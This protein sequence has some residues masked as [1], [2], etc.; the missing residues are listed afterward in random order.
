MVKVN[1]ALHFRG[2]MLPCL[3]VNSVYSFALG[4]KGRSSIIIC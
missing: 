4:G 3:G 2:S 1:G